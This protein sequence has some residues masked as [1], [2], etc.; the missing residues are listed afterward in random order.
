MLLMCYGLVDWLA[1]ICAI[2]DEAGDLAVD[3]PEQSGDFANVVCIIL[4]Q[5]TCN[6]LAGVRIDREM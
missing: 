1:I 3:L 6:S 2:R 5:C 4:G